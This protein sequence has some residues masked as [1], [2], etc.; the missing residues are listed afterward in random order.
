MSIPAP[1]ACHKNSPTVNF[2]Q[3]IKKASLPNPSSLRV[4]N[5]AS[6]DTDNYFIN[7]QKRIAVIVYTI[8]RCNRKCFLQGNAVLLRQTFA[9]SS[10]KEPSQT[11]CR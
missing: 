7:R 10:A 2:F 8:F 11:Q 1:C 5:N 6:P 4:F 9:V 3:V